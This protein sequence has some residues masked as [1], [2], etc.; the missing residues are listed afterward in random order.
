MQPVK[1]AKKT[2]DD[3]RAAS[4]QIARIER[5]LVS[6]QTQVKSVEKSYGLDNLHLT[7]ARHTSPRSC[8][9]LRS[10]VVSQN[11]QEHLTEFQSIAEIES[12]SGAAATA[13]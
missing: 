9:T 4:K 1:L 2:S 12:I 10:C 3:A 13:K 7:V 6:L 11:R 5:E 8:P